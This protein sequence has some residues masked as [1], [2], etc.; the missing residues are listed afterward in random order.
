MCH[1]IFPGSVVSLERNVLD[2]NQLDSALAGEVN[3]C[4]LLH[5]TKTEMV[6]ALESRGL[7]S[8]LSG[9]NVLF[10]HGTYF[11]ES[12]TKADQYAGKRFLHNLYIQR[13]Q[14]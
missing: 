7:D 11:T 9:P 12:S 14:T 3:E 4:Y 5:G 2:L 13:I 8:R 6:N 10:G 1:H